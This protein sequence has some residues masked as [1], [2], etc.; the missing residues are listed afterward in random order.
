MQRTIK[1]DTGG[2]GDNGERRQFR[3]LPMSRREMQWRDWDELDVILITGDAFIDHPS[4]EIAALGRVLETMGLRVGY[5]AQPDWNSEKGFTQLGRPRLF[6]AV[7]AGKHDSMAANYS[8]TRRPRKIDFFSPGRLPGL[9]PDR[10]SIVY[11]SCCKTIYPDVPVVITGIEATGRKL[12]HYDF[13][14]DVLRPGLLAECPAELLIYGPGER[15]ITQVAQVLARGQAPVEC[16]NIR[17]LVYRVEADHFDRLEE[18]LPPSYE[19]LPHFDEL[20]LSKQQFIDQ[21]NLEAD[22][23]DYHRQAKALVQRYENCTLVQTPPQRPLSTGEIDRIYAL[24][25]SRTPHP[26]YREAGPI[27]SF[28]TVKFALTTHRGCFGKCA[29]CNQRIHEGRYVSSRSRESILKEAMLISSFRYF[30]GWISNIGGPVANMWKMGCT[31]DVD[32]K[33]ACER[34]SCL[35]PEPCE[36]LALDHTAY[37]EL[38]QKVRSVDGVE[39]CY[40]ASHIRVDLLE[41]D[42]SGDAFLEEIMTHFL[43]GHIKL[44]FEHVSPDINKLI[45]KYHDGTIESFIERFDRI[46]TRIGTPELTITPYF[47]SSHPGSRLEHAID[48]A[49]FIKKHDLNSCQIQDFVPMPGTPSACMHY[50][51]I[52]PATGE[53]VYRPLAYRERKLQRS[54][55]QYYKPQNERYVFDALKEADRL[56]LIGEGGDCLLKAE[57]NWSPFD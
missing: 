27:P 43:S 49:L 45:H 42:P 54:L 52:D 50:T 11:A 34:S 18:Y 31:L 12:A 44:P 21:T 32:N 53:T 33:G 41:H 24:P 55:F 8:P 37:T 10:A 20:Q 17:G 48:I 38:L 36:H 14:D 3:H 25:Y 39:R 30:R 6:F 29:F 56:D 4:F 35:E 57:P 26:K 1:N 19:T 23:A 47:I 7:T 22:N 13:W 40:L 5:I 46:R 2:N 9:R 16:R 51:G 15:A 28:E